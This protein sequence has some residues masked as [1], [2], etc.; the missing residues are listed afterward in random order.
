MHEHLDRQVMVVLRDKRHLIG[1]L[2]SFDQYSNMVL[3]DTHE[4]HVVG[5][6]KP[7]SAFFCGQTC[8]LYCCI[9]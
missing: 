3:E 4:R 6:K 8:R 2:R 7:S 1:T 5:G 9:K